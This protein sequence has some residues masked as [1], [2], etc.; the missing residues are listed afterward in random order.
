VYSLEDQLENLLTRDEAGMKKKSESVEQKKS[1]DIKYTNSTEYTT[2]KQALLQY[3][4]H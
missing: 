3:S 2:N 1:G 4:E